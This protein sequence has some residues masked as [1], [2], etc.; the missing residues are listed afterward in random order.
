MTL[1]PNIIPT[2][3][4]MMISGKMEQP[5]NQRYPHSQQVL[6]KAYRRTKEFGLLSCGDIGKLDQ[7]NR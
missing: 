2:M 3:K 6:L 5:D 7:P 4:I 1:Q